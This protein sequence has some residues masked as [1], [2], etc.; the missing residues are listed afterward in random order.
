MV[1]RKDSSVERGIKILLDL[2]AFFLAA[3]VAFDLRY[4]I[5]GDIFWPIF[6]EGPAPWAALYHAMPY[7]LLS[8]FIIFSLFG[9]YAPRL[10]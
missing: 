1:P 4:G 10:S 9:L 7:L 6:K 5:V 2:L 3:N 8:W